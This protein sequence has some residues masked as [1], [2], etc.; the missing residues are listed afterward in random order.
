MALRFLFVDFN[1][2]FASVEQ[3]TRR[4]LR[5][6]PVAV[7]PVMTDTTCCIAASY[8]AKRF[9]IR[10][11][12]LVRE[13]KHLCPELC[14]VEARPPLYVEF[15]HALVDAVESC[16]PVYRVLSIDE[17]GCELT[18][19]QQKRD[20]A[21]ALARR[22]KETIA[23]RVGA[24]L[25][26]S[27]GIAPNLFL[28]KTASDMQKPNGLVVIEEDD[29]PDCLYSLELKDVSGVGRKMSMRLNRF[30]IYTVKELC[31]ANRAM[32]RSVWRGIEGD[33]MYDNLRAKVVRSPETRRAS[34]GHS[35]VL[36]P[37]LR[38]DEAAFSV[39][40]RLLQKA[41]TRLRSYDLATGALHVGVKY[42]N[43]E[44]WREEARFN[45]TQDDVVL[46]RALEVLWHSRAQRFPKEQ[47]A[48]PLAVGL[49]LFRLTN[50]RETTPSLFE[51]ETNNAAL[52]KALDKLNTRYGANTIYFAGAYTARE[53][54]P[55]RIAFT[56]I[57]DAVEI[58]TSSDPGSS[59]EN[60]HAPGRRASVRKRKAKI[61]PPNL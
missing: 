55:A 45:P 56:H 39:L 38:N 37:S 40:H 17:M 53:A 4:E 57:P 58:S 31:D 61:I 6:K 50:E 47:T 5:G 11:G 32:L 14:I 16:L 8:E 2:Y 22:I 46:L 25:R 21:V 29:L 59:K 30:G 19:S 12:T 13:A 9:G 33:R 54:A 60:S 18:G 10:T 15:H 3:Q 34:I 42:K 51:R 28:S 41:A 35:H 49:T 48:D 36:P 7:V 43:G 27:I 23:R 44:R 26:S 1:A 24:E 52:N 20:N